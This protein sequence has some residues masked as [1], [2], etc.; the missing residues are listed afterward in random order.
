[1]FWLIWLNKLAICEFL[2]GYYCGFCCCNMSNSVIVLYLCAYTNMPFSC[3][4]VWLKI[5]KTCWWPLKLWHYEAVQF[6]I[7]LLL[8]LL[9]LLMMCYLAVCM[10]CISAHFISIMRS[11]Y[12][13]VPNMLQNVHCRFL[14]CVM[15]WA[16]IRAGP[17]RML[18]ITMVA[19]FFKI[20]QI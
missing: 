3:A 4:C 12:W 17:M 13:Y 2:N 1:M 14:L 18:C 6:C 16:V 5:I 19:F 10:V 20:W 7:L 11:L 9:L 8:L 15:I